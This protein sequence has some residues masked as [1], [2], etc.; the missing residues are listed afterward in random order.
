[1]LMG[2]SRWS[3]QITK[4][5]KAGVI[6]IENNRKVIVANLERLRAACEIDD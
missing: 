1:M 6:E 2:S 3:R 4:L 5:R